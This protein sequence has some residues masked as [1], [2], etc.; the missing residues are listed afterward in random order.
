MKKNKKLL[1][2]ALAS[3]IVSAGPLVSVIIANR[4]KYFTTPSATVKIGIGAL[5]GFFLL[6]L[7]VLGKLKIP[8]GVCA[9]GIVFVLSYLLVPLL[10]DI[11]LIAGAALLGE[12]LDYVFIQRLIKAERTRIQNERAADVTAEKVEELFQKYIGSGRT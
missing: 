9:Y 8:S 5:I 3:F 6:F 10:Q 4:A 7:K 12:V 2:L 11:T 1:G